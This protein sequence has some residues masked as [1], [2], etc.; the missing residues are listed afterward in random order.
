[1]H[2]KAKKVVVL[3]KLVLLEHLVVLKEVLTIF[4]DMKAANFA[5]N[6]LTR[7]MLLSLFGVQ[8]APWV[9]HT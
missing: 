9:R 2:S 1:M 6:R 5:K 3:E 7:F 8:S 4:C